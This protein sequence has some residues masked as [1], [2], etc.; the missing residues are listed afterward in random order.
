MESREWYKYKLSGQVR[1]Y[2]D[3]QKKAYKGNQSTLECCPLSYST[4]KQTHALVRKSQ[5]GIFK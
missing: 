5:D 3:R 2:T 1:L 4:A